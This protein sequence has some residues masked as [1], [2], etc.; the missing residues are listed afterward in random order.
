M[1]RATGCSERASAAAIKRSASRRSKPGTTTREVSSG[2]PFV[3]VPVLSKA[4]VST[5]DSDCRASPF[6]N[7]MPSSAARPVATMMDVGVA[8]PM[9]HGQAMMRTATALTRASAREGPSTI[10]TRNVSAATARTAGTKRAVTLSTSASIGSR[11]A[12][13]S[14]TVRMMPASRVS[15]PTFSARKAKLPL[16]LIVPP[17]T[18]APGSTETGIGSPVIMD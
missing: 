18:L 5:P 3:R 1:A 13:A 8:S 11:A 17:I 10:Q 6:L 15:A 12:C 2:A 14:S 16:P 4:T 9:A 7:R